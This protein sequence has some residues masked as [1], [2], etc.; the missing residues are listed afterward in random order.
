MTNNGGRAR[1][2]ASRRQLLR[3]AGG[4]VGLSLLGA[5]AVGCEEDVAD[6]TGS[7]TP[8]PSGKGDG[9]GD[10]NPDAGA[11]GDGGVPKPLWTETAAVHPGTGDGGLIAVSGL[12]LTAG[13]PMSA[14]DGASGKEKWSLP[15]GTV[16]TSKLLVAGGRLYLPSAEYD[17]SVI[18]YDPATGQEKW[19]SRAG[20]GFRQPR[21]I[22]VDEKHVY[23]IAGIL[24]KDFSSERNVIAALDTGSGR[25]VWQ[26]QRDFGTEETGI[27]AAV[28]GNRL[29]YT[30]FKKNLTVRDTA[31][32]KQVWTQKTDKTN[33]KGFAVHEGLVILAQGRELQAFA[34][35]DGAKKWKLEAGRFGSFRQPGVVDG[36]LYV[37]DSSRTLWAV[38][39]AS[40]EKIWQSEDIAEADGKTPWQYAGAGGTLY[41]ATELDENGGV[42]AVDAAS[43]KLR[44][45]F[46][47]GSGD[48]HKWLVAT[49]G[50][51]VFAL[52]GKKL[53]ALPL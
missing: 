19:R 38:R 37:A 16:P 2:G 9:K 15:D 11:S 43:G 53:H 1:G 8:K 41:A 32:G 52:H 3:L 28:H 49:D 26:E 46:N 25:A 42:H 6:G 20:K 35:S 21:V 7:G 17:N 34:L 45:T 50:E 47:D 36:V 22:A 39:P 13:K 30:D 40:G 18:G 48:Y 4:G 12:V 44:W 27:T 10:G 24:E 33:F 31:T 29:V 51:R 14:R 23:V 5:G